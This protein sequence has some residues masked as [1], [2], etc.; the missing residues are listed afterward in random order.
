MKKEKSGI[1]LGFTLIELL[2]VMAVIGLL[3]GLTLT[4]FGSARRSARDTTRKSDIGQYRTALESYSSN[5]SGAYPTMGGS[6]QA[7]TGS[8]IFDS[9]AATN[10]IV[11][12]YL[13]SVIDDP[14]NS[15]SYTYR[16]DYFTDS[17]VPAYVLAA[18]L[19]SGGAWWICSSGKSCITGAP[20][21]PMT[22]CSCP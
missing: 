1:D 11:N 8:S 19:E 17:T 21:P 7:H 2:V 20:T 16:Y 9:A 18:P 4:G 14:V 3:A 13:P 15:A 5:Y 12:E 10:P 6:S 22:A